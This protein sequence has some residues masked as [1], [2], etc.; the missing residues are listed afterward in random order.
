[1]ESGL[2]TVFKNTEGG[3]DPKTSHLMARLILVIQLATTVTE[4]FSSLRKKL[5]SAIPDSK[6][7]FS[8][9]MKESANHSLYLSP[10]ARRNLL[11]Y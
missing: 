5:Q 4:Y 8:Y 9:Y 10:T 7:S 11:N 2:L 6:H 1:M 3:R